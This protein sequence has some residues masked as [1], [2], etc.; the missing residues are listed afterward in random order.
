MIVGIAGDVRSASAVD[1]DTASSFAVLAGA[2]VSDSGTNSSVITG[3]VGLSPTGG[4]G[5]TVLSCSQVSGTIYDTNAGY[6]GG[7]DSDTTCLQTSA[8]IL[9]AAKADVSLA[10]NDAETQPQDFAVTASTT[11]SF[12]AFPGYVLTPGVYNSGSTMGVP[13]ALTLDGGGDSNATFIFQAGS[14]LST[15]AGSM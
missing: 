7:F 5:I 8:G 9:T 4:T 11:D 13:V 6:T 3:H 15:V 14:T 2:A 1:L 12:A 10:Y